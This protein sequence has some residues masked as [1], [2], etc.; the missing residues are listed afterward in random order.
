MVT[1]STRSACCSTMA[2]AARSGTR[3]SLRAP[4]CAPTPSRRPGATRWW[5][6]RRWTSPVLASASSAPSAPASARS[7]PIR[8]MMW[9]PTVLSCAPVS[10]C[11]PSLGQ[12]ILDQREDEVG[13]PHDAHVGGA[14]QDRELRAGDQPVHLHCVLE[15]D[16]VMVAEYQQCRRGNTAELVCRPP[17]HVCRG[18]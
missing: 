1:S 11:S 6:S 17:L 12:E 5:C 15:A 18:P 2:A 7:S 9:W 16:E 3:G 10:T 8:S 14:G 4:S 13:P